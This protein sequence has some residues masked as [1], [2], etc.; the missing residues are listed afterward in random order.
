ML[1]EDVSS[2]TVAIMLNA[3][4]SAIPA[5]GRPTFL[6]KIMS[7]VESGVVVKAV[8]TVK[9]VVLAPFTYLNCPMP[10]PELQYNHDPSKLSSQAATVTIV[11][12][13]LDTSASFAAAMS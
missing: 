13:E 3:V 11:E 10:V 1:V 12:V 8:L 6:I 9:V 4:S 7:V 5:V 2:N